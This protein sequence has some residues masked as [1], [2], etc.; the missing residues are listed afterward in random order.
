MIFCRFFQR[1]F[2]LIPEKINKKIN[3]KQTCRLQE[4]HRRVQDLRKNTNKWDDYNFVMKAVSENGLDLKKR[5]ERL[6]DN[7]DVVTF[8]VDENPESLKYASERLR[9][10]DG[11]VIIALNNS[12]N[13][14]ILRYASKRVHDNFL[15]NSRE[16]KYISF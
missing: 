7:I 10:N 14:D 5:S 2:L 12:E 9:D 3:K 4:D 16:K 6:R 1:H 15:I 8:A 11:I 13:D